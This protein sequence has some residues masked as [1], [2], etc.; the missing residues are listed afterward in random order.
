ML[1]L[2]YN[3]RLPFIFQKFSNSVM[4]FWPNW[5]NLFATKLNEST[6]SLFQ[7]YD[8]CCAYPKLV[9]F[10]IIFQETIMCFCSTW[11]SSFT[12]SF[13]LNIVPSGK[14]QE[15]HFIMRVW[16]SFSKLEVSNSRK[17]P[18]TKE[19]GEWLTWPSVYIT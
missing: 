11:S 19:H 6:D 15:P 17:I 10:V 2:T 18:I 5:E 13:S 14:K 8:I 1:F 3:R 4:L 7:L 16:D 12:K 9:L